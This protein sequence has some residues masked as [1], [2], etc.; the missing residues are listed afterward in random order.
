MNLYRLDPAEITDPLWRKL[1][2]ER[3]AIR[4]AQARCKRLG[5]PVTVSKIDGRTLRVSEVYTA[6]PENAGK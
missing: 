5:S 3:G 6:K 2:G 4:A 1:R